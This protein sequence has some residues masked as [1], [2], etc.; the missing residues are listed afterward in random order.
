MTVTIEKFDNEYFVLC[1][2]TRKYKNIIKQMRG[3]WFTELANGPGWMFPISQVNNVEDK[4]SKILDM[5]NRLDLDES[6]LSDVM[7][8]ILQEIV[9][10]NDRSNLP[11]LNEYINCMNEPYYDQDSFLQGFDAGYDRGRKEMFSCHEIEYAIT[12]A[13]VKGYDAGFKNGMKKGQCLVRSYE[14]CDNTMRNQ[15]RKE[16]FLCMLFNTIMCTL[17]M[18]AYFGGMYWLI[19]INN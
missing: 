4:F 12:N 9:D 18:I 15:V 16:K 10:E 3:K 8:Q 14:G 17:L 2:D 11:I 5:N 13:Y 7:S 1:G 19:P 6:K